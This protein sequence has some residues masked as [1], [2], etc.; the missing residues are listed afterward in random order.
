MR[1]F[2]PDE[3][4]A[5]AATGVELAGAADFA[6]D[7]LGAGAFFGVAACAAPTTG[8]ALGASPVEFG[9]VFAVAEAAGAGSAEAGSA[10][11]TD[12]AAA[13]AD[14]EGSAARTGG[15]EP[16][17]PVVLPFVEPPSRFPTRRPSAAAAITTRAPTPS[18]I[19]DLL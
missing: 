15:V 11:T 7:A 1:N 18:A 3:V 8:R 4:A 5:G 6:A 2:R 9:A 14:S 19:R 12:A 10:T 17:Q 13:G 16:E